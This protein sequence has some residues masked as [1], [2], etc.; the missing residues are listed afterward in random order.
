MKSAHRLCTVLVCFALTLLAAHSQS[1]PPAA[2]EAGVRQWLDSFTK[3]F[4][5]R[6][7]NAIMALY[8]PDVVA[9][10]VVPPL[11]YTGSEAYGKDWDTFFAQ[12]KGPLTMEVQDLHIQVSGDLAMMEAL[13]QVSGTM[14]NGQPM[15]MWIRDT[16]GLRKVNGKWLDFHDHVSVP[17]DLATGK[18]AM[19]LKP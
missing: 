6:D 2:D 17:V 5:A 12:F 13:E 10:D 18:A 11:Q 3:A 16:T 4:N 9:Y 8:A 15:N 19:D 1:A 7:R 14:T